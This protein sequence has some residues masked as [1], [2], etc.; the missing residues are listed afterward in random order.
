MFLN[1][2]VLCFTLHKHY[3]LVKW[4]K[5][6]CEKECKKK[7]VARLTFSMREFMSSMR[8]NNELVNYTPLY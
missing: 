4:A 5:F 8:N 6:L 1:K 3:F 7:I 2:G